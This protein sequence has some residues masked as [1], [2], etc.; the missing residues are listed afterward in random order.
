[1][2]ESMAAREIKLN[3]MM[4]ELYHTEKYRS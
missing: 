4:Q 2:G 3:F 1:V